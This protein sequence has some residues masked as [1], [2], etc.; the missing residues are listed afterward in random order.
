M[1]KKLQ[2][3]FFFFFFLSLEKLPFYWLLTVKTGDLGKQKMF[4][5]KCW[6]STQMNKYSACQL[7]IDSDM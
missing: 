2:Q 3:L 4:E 5:K 6:A 7:F 1:D